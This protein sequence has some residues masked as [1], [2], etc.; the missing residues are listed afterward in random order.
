ML[1]VRRPIWICIPLA[2]VALAVL[3]I[4]WKRH[5]LSSPA[6][7]RPAFDQLAGILRPPASVL[8][9]QR[10]ALARERSLSAGKRD[11]HNVVWDRDLAGTPTASSC[12]TSE[13]P[14]HAIDDDPA[15]AWRGSGEAEQWTLPFKRVVHV[16]LIRA[17]YGDSAVKGVPS[18][19]RWEYLQPN[20][21]GRCESATRF[22]P[23]PDGEVDDRHPNEFVHGPKNVHAQKQVLFA[24]TDACALRL[25]VEATE[26]GAGPVVREIGV[27]ESAPSVTRGEGVQVTA[28]GAHAVIAQSNPRHVVD[29]RYE[30][31]WSGDPDASPWSLEIQLPAVN[32]IDRIALTLGYDGVTAAQKEATGRVYTGGYLPLRYTVETTAELSP[33]QWERVEEAAPEQL[34]DEPLP[35]R[36]RLVKLRQARRVRALRLTI[37]E[38]TGLWGEPQR[39][40]PVVRELGLYREGDP[41][42]VIQ[43]PLFLS[44][45]ANPSGLTHSSKGGEAYSDG[46]FARDVYH[47]LR[48]IV[49]GFDTDTRWPADA[50]RKRDDG[51]GR[52]LE[53][54]EGDDPLLGAPFVEAMSPPPVLILSGGMNWD[55]GNRTGRSMQRPGAWVWNAVA[56]ARSADRGMG[57]LGPVVRGRMAPLI[58]LCGGAQILAMLEAMASQDDPVR[59]ILLVRNS[60]DAVRGILNSEAR[61]ERAWWFDPAKSDALRPVIEFDPSDRLFETLAGLD[62]ARRASRE[63]PSSHYDMLRLSK[64]DALLSGLVVSSWSDYCHP[65]V[66]PAG[67]EPTWEAASGQRCV[68]IPQA[69]HSR[70]ESRYPVIGFQFH[71]EQRDLTR[72]APGSRAED[73][74][75]ALNVFA[76]AVDMVVESYLRVWWPGA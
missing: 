59:D 22:L 34:I 51:T 70:D 33:E 65:W 75:D 73:R 28:Q 49:L 10:A 3:A 32:M 38:A 58:G 43:P 37:S 30:T 16:G 67:P 64:F 56:D 66:S 35:I 60:N 6:H 55:H 69:F 36:R 68:R 8:A 5:E 2:A 18:H 46:G 54:M 7:A 41:R 1:R 47:R 29:G 20:P 31:L 12:V 40:A 63:F 11:V 4:G 50:S 19:Y 76:N 71:P 27:Y 74:G 17:W 9:R 61:T 62:G 15:T 53:C 14:I 25:V 52:F 42:P 57:A 24:D 44:V 72:L 45:N 23:M 13:L 26:G 48:R 39:A 21:A